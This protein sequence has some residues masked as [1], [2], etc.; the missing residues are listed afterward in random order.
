MTVDLVIRAQGG[1]HDAFEVLARTSID[2]LYGIARRVLRDPTAAEDAVQD[3]LV[4][5]WRDLRALRE[6]ARFDAWLYRLLLNSCRDELRRSRRRPAVV[7]L[8][9]IGGP[10][11]EDQYAAVARRDEIAR[12]F[13]RLSIEHRMALTLHL[14]LGLGATEIARVLGVPEG[15]ATSRIHYGTRALRAILNEPAPA[16]AAPGAVR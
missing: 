15:T 13:A 7:T 8:E 1:D 5:A 14:H 9:S 12:G 11:A 3:C 16:P 2:R 4:R 6:P 10:A